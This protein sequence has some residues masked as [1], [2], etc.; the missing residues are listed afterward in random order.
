[1]KK[2]VVKGVAAIL[3][4]L[5]CILNVFIRLVV[6]DL[7]SFVLAALFLVLGFFLILGGFGYAFPKSPDRDEDNNPRSS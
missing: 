2:R 4:G 7:A 3:L 6:I 5:L 1:M